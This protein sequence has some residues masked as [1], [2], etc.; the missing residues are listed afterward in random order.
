MAAASTGTFPEPPELAKQ[1]RTACPAGVFDIGSPCCGIAGSTDVW[2]AI[3][4]QT[5]YKS[6]YDIESRYADCL[7]MQLGENS[8]VSLGVN[9]GDIRA[10]DLGILPGLDIITSGPP[11]PPWEHSLAT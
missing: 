4:L 10:I 8:A 6:H 5:R 11:C 1:F 2:K 3:G 7:K 9:M